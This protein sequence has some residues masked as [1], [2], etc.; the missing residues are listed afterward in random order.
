MLSMVISSAVRNNGARPNACPCVIKPFS[1]QRVENVACATS[2]ET[3]SFFAAAASNEVR[4][5]TRGLSHN[6]T[7]AL[8]H[9]I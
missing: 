8:P 1:Q 6:R 2:S 4:D 7:I 9:T 3:N 5:F